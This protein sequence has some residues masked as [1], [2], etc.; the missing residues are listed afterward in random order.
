M[1]VCCPSSQ[2]QAEVPT[3]YLP[4][5]QERALPRRRLPCSL[6]VPCR[7]LGQRQRV[8]QRQ[9]QQRRLGAAQGTHVDASCGVL[10]QAQA[11]AAAA[12]AY[13]HL[14]AQRGQSQS[15]CVF[16]CC[17]RWGVSQ[18]QVK[19]Q[20]ELRMHRLHVPRASAHRYRHMLL[21][22]VQAF[23]CIWTFLHARHGKVPEGGDSSQ[24][25]MKGH[26]GAAS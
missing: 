26:L 2:M 19:L 8:H 12:G 18:F 4:L 21:P 7:R 5:Q 9:L 6:G 23:T 14:R 10:T 1:H 3:A 15:V 11:P 17:Q 24:Y 22:P 25:G 13:G 16:V 20:E